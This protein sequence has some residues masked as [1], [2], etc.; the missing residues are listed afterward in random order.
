MNVITRKREFGMLRA[1]GMTRGQIRRMTVIEGITYGFSGALLGSILGVIFS[2]FIYLGAR[3]SIILSLAAELK[4]QIHYI[5][6][7][8]VFVITMLITTVSTLIPL[9]RTTSMEVVEAIRAIE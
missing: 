3:G 5:V 7:S 8:I 4:W 9:K 6:I 1:I 2:Y